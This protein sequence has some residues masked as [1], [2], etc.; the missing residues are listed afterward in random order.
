MS[1]AHTDAGICAAIDHG[2]DNAA[3]LR[4][5]NRLGLAAAPTFALMA[6]LSGIDAGGP[7]DMLCSAAHSASP[8][9]GMTLMYVLMSVFHVG[10]WLKW[11]V[12][13]R[14]GIRRS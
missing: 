11:I 1:D 6:L 10:P 2:S 14:R 13:R 7:M 3:S 12:C 9:S 4:A 8:L 5:A